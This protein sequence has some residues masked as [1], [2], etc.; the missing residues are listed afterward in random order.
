MTSFE[1]KGYERGIRDNLIELRIDAIQLGLELKYGS[2]AE[3]ISERVKSI[4]D[5][6]V[7]KH[8]FQSLRQPLTLEEFE[9]LLPV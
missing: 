9:A 7:L 8:L 2:Q 6:A 4:Q 5:P 3:V 1:R